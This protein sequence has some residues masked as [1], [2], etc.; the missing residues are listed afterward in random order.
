MNTLTPQPFPQIHYFWNNPSLSHFYA[1]LDP[2]SW[3]KYR[4]KLVSDIVENRTIMPFT[5]FCSKYNIST[6]YRFRHLQ[7]AHAFSSQFPACLLQ[8]KCS[9]LEAL[10]FSESLEKPASTL[11][12]HFL[13]VAYSN[14]LTQKQM[15]CRCPR[16]G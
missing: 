12:I 7:N 8:L 14:L 3:A 1:L 10:L 11:Y 16:P 2:Q 5:S 9:G 15:A 4:I 13:M 6:H